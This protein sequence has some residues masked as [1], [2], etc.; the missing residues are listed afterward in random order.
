[1]EDTHF[2]NKGISEEQCLRQHKKDY[3]DSLAFADIG[4]VHEDVNLSRDERI[5]EFE[6]EKSIQKVTDTINLRREI[7]SSVEGRKELPTFTEV[8]SAEKQRKLREEIIKDTTQPLQC[9]HP[10]KLSDIIFKEVSLSTEP[11]NSKEFLVGLLLPF[12]EERLSSISLTRERLLYRWA[13]YCGSTELL[14]RTDVLLEKRLSSLSREYL[15]LQSAYS[16]L[17]TLHENY[18]SETSSYK[19]KIDIQ[20]VRPLKT[21]PEN[22]KPSGPDIDLIRVWINNFSH[23]SLITRRYRRFELKCKW[24]AITKRYE[25]TQPIFNRAVEHAK[26][27]LDTTTDN[28]I[29]KLALTDEEIESVLEE[30]STSF[31]ISR[32]N[33]DSQEYSYVVNKRFSAIFSSQCQAFEFLPYELAAK[34]RTSNN[35]NA[36]DADAEGP[37]DSSFKQSVPYV[38]TFLVHSTWLPYESKITCRGKQ[39]PEVEAVR[40]RLHSNGGYVDSSLRVEL[41][42]LAETDSQYVTKRLRDQAATHVERATVASNT[43]MKD[44]RG[45]HSVGAQESSAIPGPSPHK[46]QALYFLRYIRIREFRRRLLD[47]L[48]YYASL[49]RRLCLDSY[50]YASSSVGS[51]SAKFSKKLRSGFQPDK[52]STNLVKKFV[53]ETSVRYGINDT[54][55]SYTSRI[56]QFN[57]NCADRSSVDE[58]PQQPEVDKNDPN[59]TS[60]STDATYQ[61]AA[62]YKEAE[63]QNRDDTYRVT[64]LIFYYYFLFEKKKTKTK[65]NKTGK[66][67]SVIDRFGNSVMYTVALQDLEDLENELLLTASHYLTVTPL[68]TTG[69][70]VDRAAVLEDIFESETWFQS[71]KRKV[72]DTYMEAYEHCGTADE[73]IKL[74]NLIFE[75]M[76]KRPLLD[77]SHGYFIYSYTAETISNELQYSLLRDIINCQIADEKKITSNLYK[78]TARKDWLSYGGFPEQSVHDTRLY[79]HL[80]PGSSVVNVLEFYGSLS[81]IASVPKLLNE[82]TRTICS[83]FSVRGAEMSNVKQHILQLMIV[84]W[85]VCIYLLSYVS[86]VVLATLCAAC[87][88]LLLSSYVI[89]RNIQIPFPT[90]FPHRY[91]QRKK[92]YNDNFRVLI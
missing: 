51:T 25:I 37:S 22:S 8:K 60:D 45:N 31:K 84:E 89:E 47:T 69:Q 34:T 63:L 87:H 19:D 48:N 27:T 1:M 29:P 85:K 74:S 30:L 6:L 90:I 77:L 41:G 17:L 35:R 39:S 7:Y 16:N 58:E 32:V 67:I 49:R 81:S 4:T 70:D 91:L 75:E 52:Q 68:S 20:T 12:Y 5:F 11:K 26:G 18:S 83:K 46:K 15:F 33:D 43:S 72:I 62:F 40:C 10:Q 36:A 44:D 53:S 57:L 2:Q 64:G 24:L 42:F 38:K 88:V 86:K 3:P 82:L 73:Q 79:Q 14:A 54:E 76:I 61:E 59:G 78:N 23:K 55:S 65:Q 56:L 71:S 80:F 92:E 13:R 66:S 9:E 50:G 21:S 28:V